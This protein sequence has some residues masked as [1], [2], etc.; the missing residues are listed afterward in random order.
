[1]RPDI[2]EALRYLGIHTS[3]DPSLRSLAENL[4][5]E[6]TDRIKPRS[7]WRPLPVTRENGVLCLAGVPLPGHSA[8]RMLAD[9]RQAA[10]L[11]CTLGA[12]FDLWLRRMQAR[13]MSAA[14]V[15]D[16]LGSAYVEA[17]CD[18]AEAEIAARYPDIYLTDR[19]SPGYGD[20]PL[21]LQ[22]M[23]LEQ[24]NARRIGV[25]CTD[26]LLMTPQKTV[27]ALIGLADKPQPARIRGC[28]H[29]SMNRTCTL[30]KAGNTCEL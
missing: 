10:L 15:L 25:A 4:A 27:S 2:D 30:R 23:L 3:A 21:S 6:L 13:D 16:A 29:C 28:A 11:L 18:A 26:T 19:F 9:C 24:V 1:M 12:E 14:V 7:I 20:L 22:P 17:A 5:Q 8:A